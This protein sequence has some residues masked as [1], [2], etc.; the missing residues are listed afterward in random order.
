V[1]EPGQFRTDF[2][3]KGKTQVKESNKPDYKQLVDDLNRQFI[4]VNGS[5]KG[6]PQLAANAII[7]LSRSSAPPLRIPLG[8]DA[9]SWTGD[10]LKL[11]NEELE[12]WKQWAI[13]TAFDEI[14]SR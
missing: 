11:A 1:I 10:R 12:T 6:S 3:N 4:A 7:Q 8:A 2:F 9:V 14:Q 5:Q 13:N